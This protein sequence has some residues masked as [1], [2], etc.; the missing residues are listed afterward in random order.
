MTL[1][2]HFAWAPGGRVLSF[3]DTLRRRDRAACVGGASALRAWLGRPPVAPTVLVVG[4]STRV[5]RDLL[6]SVEL[7]TG[8]APRVEVAEGVPLEGRLHA[9]L[10]ELEGRERTPDAELL[11]EAAASLEDAEI[12]ELSR[13]ARARCSAGVARAVHLVRA[14]GR[15]ELVARPASKPVW[16]RPDGP[17][18]GALDGPSGVRVNGPDGIERAGAPLDWVDAW[19]ASAPRPA[20]ELLALAHRRDIAGISCSSPAAAASDTPSHSTT[21]T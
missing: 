3:L 17:R 13:R 9:L 8:R 10:R 21:I 16:W 12:A 1:R 7:R 14:T 11:A 4:R 5:P 20:R 15:A 19:L 6:G 2:R 18:C